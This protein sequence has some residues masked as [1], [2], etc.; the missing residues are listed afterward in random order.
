[1]SLYKFLGVCV[2]VL[3]LVYRCVLQ[4]VHY[5][6]GVWMLT[7]S[8]AAAPCHE[9]TCKAQH[10][11][12]KSRDWVEWR[13][14]HPSLWNAVQAMIDAA[15]SAAAFPFQLA[16]FTTGLPRSLGVLM[17]ELPGHIA[18]AIMGRGPLSGGAPANDDTMTT[19]GDAAVHPSSS[20]STDIWSLLRHR[21]WSMETLTVAERQRLFMYVQNAQVA[22]HYATLSFRDLEACCVVRSIR[23]GD[24]N[25]KSSHSLILK[26]ERAD[27]V[28][29]QRAR[30][31][32]MGC[33]DDSHRP[34]D[35]RTVW[36]CQASC[37][38]EEMR[39]LVKRVQRAMPSLH[40]SGRCDPY[41]GP[42]PRPHP[43]H[44][45][46]FYAKARAIFERECASLEKKHGRLQASARELLWLMVI[47]SDVTDGPH[48]PGSEEQSTRARTMIRAE[49]VVS[50]LSHYA[51]SD[52]VCLARAM[53]LKT[54][55]DSNTAAHLEAL[56]KYLAARRS[57]SIVSSTP[58]APER[59]LRFPIYPDALPKLMCD[60]Y[61]QADEAQLWEEV[62]ARGLNTSRPRR[63]LLKIKTSAAMPTVLR[64]LLEVSD[65]ALNAAGQEHGG[66]YRAA[67]IRHLPNASL[68]KI[69]VSVGLKQGDRSSHDL[70]DALE[71]LIERSDKTRSEC[72]RWQE[73]REAQAAELGLE[74]TDLD[75]TGWGRERVL[76]SVKKRPGMAT[77]SSPR[78]RKRVQHL[79]RHSSS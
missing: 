10:A 41:A 66:C 43:K 33:L 18:C 17:R 78:K 9:E 4:Y 16:S 51:S 55:R 54:C 37:G 46:T 7:C 47:L 8:L 38:S 27:R 2:C 1:M 45:I 57:T 62:E 44:D 59:P 58:P 24:H 31:L 14:T 6:G 32:P 61:R 42:L 25:V 20:S 22:E 49:A 48:A 3:V 73:Q 65:S 35:A 19:V 69:A 28:W 74:A 70:V 11:L 77:P 15:P 71:R 68:K 52:L 23:P 39:A 36:P 40:W 5:C 60:W 79:S 26:L 64:K 13:E 30:V 53:G 12:K 34:P 63:R 75:W 29:A 72:L 76:S 50:D 67:D 56:R 21:I